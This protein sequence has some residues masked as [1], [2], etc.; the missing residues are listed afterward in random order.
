MH[1]RNRNMNLIQL[2]AVG[3]SN[4]QIRSNRTFQRNYG[5]R[6]TVEI[7]CRIPL[8]VYYTAFIRILTADTADTYT[9]QLP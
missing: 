8:T 4:V 5:I 7:M 1:Y 9:D 3:A 2:V 6:F